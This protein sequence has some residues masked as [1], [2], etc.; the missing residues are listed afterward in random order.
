MSI[1]KTMRGA[2]RNGA[3]QPFSAPCPGQGK[4][5]SGYWIC[6]LSLERGVGPAKRRLLAWEIRAM[7]RG[8]CARRLGLS[9][10]PAQTPVWRMFPY[11]AEP[12]LLR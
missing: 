5:F 12:I 1:A 9:S 3:Q 10:P 8:V 11:G 7:Q 2:K 4:A 6:P